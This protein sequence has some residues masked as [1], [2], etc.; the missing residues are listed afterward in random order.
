MSQA[1]AQDNNLTSR[2][3]RGRFWR[4]VF[5]SS[6]T[7]G[8]LAL[9][10]LLLTVINQSMGLVVIRYEVQPAEISARPL[11]E[12]T[13]DELIA[14]LQDNL[15]L[16]R[17]RTLQREQPLAERTR[18]EVYQLVVV[19]VLQP[20]LEATYNLDA[21]LFDRAA[22]EA[23]VAE[24]YP[25]ARLEFRSWLNGDFLT[26][27]LSRDPLQAGISIPLQGSLAIILVTIVVAFPI[28]VGAAIYL[29]EYAT[30]NRINRIIQ[31]NI[32]NLAGVPSI[33]YGILGLALFVRGIGEFTSGA[34]FGSAS[35]NGRTVLSAGL[36]MALLILPVLIINAQEAIRAVPGTLRQAAFGLGATRW[37]T[38]WHHVLPAA[39]P[40]IMTGAILA[41]SRAIGETAPLI[42]VGASSFINKAP[43]SAFSLFTAIPIQIYNWTSSSQLGFRNIAAA[44]I[45][46]LL[47][48]LLTINALA[49]LIRNR[50]SKRW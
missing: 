17:F 25:D 36:T 46:V 48:T 42:L 33:V 10:I 13:Q 8:I 50:F 34:V 24:K 43:D 2:H 4:A 5:F 7:I 14:V 21:S 19:E 18:Q 27:S 38:V 15:R 31:T 6:T 30:K 47:I 41:V 29:E 39:M 49:I 44:A 23:E 37:Q 16:A 22:I 40:G 26:H 28:G 45:I 12:L 1:P 11:E 32:D 3:R 35:A 20:Q 9:V